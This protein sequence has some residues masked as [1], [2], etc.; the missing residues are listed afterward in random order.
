ME[1]QDTVQFHEE[2]KTITALLTQVK[3]DLEVVKKEVHNIHSQVTDLPSGR[4]FAES[5]KR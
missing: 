4:Q 5:T 3:A 2:L 1:T